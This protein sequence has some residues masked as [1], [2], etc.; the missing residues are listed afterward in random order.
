MSTHAAHARSGVGKPRMSDRPGF[1]LSEAAIAARL[2]AHQL[3]PGGNHTYAKGDDQYPL[4]SPP[5][6]VRGEGCHEWDVDGNRFIGYSLGQR[7]VT[8]GHG[9]PEVVEAVSRAVKNGLNFNRPS[10]LEGDASEALLAIV[11]GAD[12][13]KFTKDGST[14][15]TAAVKLARAATGRSPAATPPARRRRG[16]ARRWR[17]RWGC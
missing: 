11:P 17:P 2:R 6:I 4:H 8:L 7:C 15:N 13:V 14:A 3:I 1:F 10:L 9:R 12:M 16:C 5:V